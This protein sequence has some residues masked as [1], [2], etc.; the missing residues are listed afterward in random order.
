[1]FLFDDKHP[2]EYKKY[3]EIAKNLVE[4]ID[5]CEKVLPKGKWQVERT[6]VISFIFTK[7]IH[8]TFQLF[9]VVKFCTDTTWVH[10]P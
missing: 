10:I 6:A 3:M 4:N 9:T 7:S 5:S 2:Q 8:G 1:M